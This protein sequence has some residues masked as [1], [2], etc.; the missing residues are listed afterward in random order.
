MSA[1]ARGRF[2][3]AMR[4]TPQPNEWTRQAVE[5]FADAVCEEGNGWQHSDICGTRCRCETPEDHQECRALL[6]KECGLSD[7]KETDNA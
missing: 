5:A 6:L 7:G 4:R 3:E 1:T 2:V